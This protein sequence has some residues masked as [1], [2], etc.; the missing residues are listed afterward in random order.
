MRVPVPRDERAEMDGHDATY[1]PVRAY[2]FLELALK[3]LLPHLA[4][5]SMLN[6]AGSSERDHAAGVPLELGHA[7]LILSLCSLQE[8]LEV[9]V[10]LLQ[11]LNFL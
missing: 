5:G 6:Y 11:C 1:L 10:L 3:H 9:R 7:P 2:E 8:D 4:P